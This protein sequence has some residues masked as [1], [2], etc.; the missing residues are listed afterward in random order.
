LEW[1]GPFD[2]DRF[3]PAMATNEM[4]KGLPDWRTMDDDF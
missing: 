1:A 3:D 2:P 4:K